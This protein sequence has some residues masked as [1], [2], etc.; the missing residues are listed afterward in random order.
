MAV[1]R[2]P[3]MPTDSKRNPARLDELRAVVE[4][5]TDLDEDE[6]QFELLQSIRLLLALIADCHLDIPKGCCERTMIASPV[7]AP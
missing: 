1:A 3:L 7:G 4:P 6:D 2:L 5:A